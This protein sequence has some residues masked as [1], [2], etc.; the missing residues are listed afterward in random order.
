ML[1]LLLLAIALITIVVITFVMLSVGG[2][3][4]LIVFGDLI[5]AIAVIVFIVKFIRNRRR[6]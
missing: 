3:A 6:K 5:V 2:A 4:F 1:T